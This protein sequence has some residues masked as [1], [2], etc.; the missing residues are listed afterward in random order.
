[1]SRYLR[2]ISVAILLI[3]LSLPL[4]AFAHEEVI[5]GSYRLEVG[6]MNEPVIVG[7]ANALFLFI[8]PVEV[9][10]EEEH[11]EEAAEG[12]EHTEEETEQSEG[13]APHTGGVEGAAATLEFTIE[14]GGVSQSYPLRPVSDQPGQYTADF[15]PTR[16][17]QY[18]FR[19][20]GTIEGETVDVEAQVEEVEAVGN[21]AFPEPL[22]SST[23]LTTQLAEAQSQ[24]Q[25]AQTIAIVAAVLG[26][27]GLGVGGY[28]L[29]SRR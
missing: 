26:L 5:S 18:T 3:C 2:L 20:S 22:P 16:E 9:A 25:T 6:W 12:E 23:E 7:Q 27:L 19:F 28:S 21:L 24:A 8:E 1:M 11:T 15:I 10:A 4:R 13:E 17:G 14:Y 29:V